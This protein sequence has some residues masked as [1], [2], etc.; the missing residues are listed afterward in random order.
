MWGTLL[1]LML[2]L[3]VNKEAVYHFLFF[4]SG[5]VS[6]PLHCLQYHFSGNFF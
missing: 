3:V 6:V 1:L 5:G 4:L 2:L